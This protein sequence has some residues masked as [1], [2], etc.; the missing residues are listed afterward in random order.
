MA[1]FSGALRSTSMACV[2]LLLLLLLSTTVSLGEPDHH[3]R[4][5]AGLTGRR[6][7]V[8]AGSNTVSSPAATAVISVPRSGCAAAAMPYSESKRSSPGG[9]DPQHH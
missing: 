4:R 6:M 3:H 2:V 9:P 1:Y 5:L 8:N 7:L